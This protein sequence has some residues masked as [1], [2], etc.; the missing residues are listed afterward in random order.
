MKPNL[1]RLLAFVIAVIAILLFLKFRSGSRAHADAAQT[2]S[3][4]E[5]AAS[6][7]SKAG[8]RPPGRHEPRPDR[9]RAAGK[10]IG[11]ADLERWLAGFKGSPRTIAEANATV[12]LLNHNADLIRK[13]IEMD[14]DNPLL[15]YLGAVRRDFSDEERLLLAEA[16]FKQDSDNS[17]AAYLYAAQL[18]KS[19]DTEKAIEILGSATERR[20]MNDHNARMGE[21]FEEAFAGAGMSRDM[22]K[23]LSIAN[24][25][26]PYLRDFLS[27][28]DSLNEMAK[29]LPP[30]KAAEINSL[31][32]TMG[33]RVSQRTEPGTLLNHLAGLFLEE[34]TLAGLPDDAPSP[35]Q[36]LTVAEARESITIERDRLKE[37]M[38]RLPEIE[39]LLPGNP[40]L[41]NGYVERFRTLG[42]AEALKWLLE[43]TDK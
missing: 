28:S 8:A 30:E 27:F 32:A 24:L 37:S 7:T 6:G 18:L 34:K 4:T 39:T 31:N 22:A 9:E 26:L 1:T 2:N 11:A 5:H 43:E 38:K 19:G 23:L 21:M 41:T 42:E 3:G 33:S 35:Y 20:S 15:L 14:P 13:A 29:T 17:M 12:G 10:E 40:E 36:G 16:F 25:S